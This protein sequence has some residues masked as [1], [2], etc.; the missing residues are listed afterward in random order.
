MRYY[1]TYFDHNYLS[2]GLALYHSLEKHAKPFTLWVLCFDDTTLRSLR[3]LNLYSLIPVALHELEGDDAE[4]LAVKS[5]RTTVEYY[6]TSTPSLPL[7]ILNRFPQ[8][9]I[10]TYLDADL[11]FY[12]SP[13]PIFDELAG[14]SVLVIPHGFPP[15]LRHLEAFGIY[16]VGFL[17]FRNDSSG[18]ECLMWWRDRCVEWCYD[19]TEDGRYADQKYLDDWPTRFSRVAVLQHR[20]AGVAPWNWMGHRVRKNGHGITVDG[21]PL[22]FYHFHSLKRLNR[23]IYSMG[24]WPYG[25]ADWTL[26]RWLYLRYIEELSRAEHECRAMLSDGSCPRGATARD[27]LGPLTWARSIVHGQLLLAIG[28]RA[29]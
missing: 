7:Y 10:I 29:I 26:Q 28:T 25:R 18:R 14:R 27:S 16:N 5:T 20:G 13:Q 12:S 11:F 21:Q 3:R 17:S 8:V 23:W 9:D 1:C 24:T 2:R 15:R 22:I 19:R 6:F 4:L